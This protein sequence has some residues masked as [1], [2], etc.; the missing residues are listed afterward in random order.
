MT[1]PPIPPMP[2][3]WYG[4]TI[5]EFLQSRPDAIVGQLTAHSEFAVISTRGVRVAMINPLMTFLRK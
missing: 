1:Q 2:R 4:A 5:A 3:A